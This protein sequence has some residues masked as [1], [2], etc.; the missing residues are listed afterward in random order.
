M[1]TVLISDE[2]GAF[3]IGQDLLGIPGFL[4]EG[5]L[6][7]VASGFV[8]LVVPLTAEKFKILLREGDL[9]SRF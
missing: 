8:N 6:G 9:H 7:C 4:R 3:F 1:K 2:P 5:R